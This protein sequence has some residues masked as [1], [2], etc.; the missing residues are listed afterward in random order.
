MLDYASP[1]QRVEQNWRSV[2]QTRVCY[3]SGKFGILRGFSCYCSISD[4][5][6]SDLEK[7]LSVAYMLQDVIALPKLAWVPAVP[8]RRCPFLA[9]VLVSLCQGV[10]S[11]PLR[12]ASMPLQTEEQTVTRW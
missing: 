12:T 2:F 6:G 10:A 11:T 9:H 5:F 3:C 8:E 4:A 1:L 7:P